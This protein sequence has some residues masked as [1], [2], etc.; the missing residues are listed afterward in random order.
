MTSAA[1]VV[2]ATATSSSHP[3]STRYETS[4]SR[5]PAR[6]PALAAGS[7]RVARRRAS[8]PPFSRLGGPAVSVGPVRF[9]RPIRANWS[10][11]RPEGLQD[12]DQ[13][14]GCCGPVR[15]TSGRGRPGRNSEPALRPTTRV[16]GDRTLQRRRRCGYPSPAGSRQPPS[17]WHSE[18]K[19]LGSIFAVH[20]E[21]KLFGCFVRST[22][23]RG[24]RVAPCPCLLPKMRGRGVSF[25]MVGLMSSRPLARFLVGAGSRAPG[26]VGRS[27]C[28]FV[29]NA[30]TGQ[31]GSPTRDAH[32]ERTGANTQWLRTSTE[33]RSPAT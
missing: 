11:F 6:C 3:G 27:H 20:S 22:A 12:A 8:A 10:A 24:Q 14:A 19:P 5:P 29:R 21:A 18:A 17:K 25:P 15:R 7:R 13:F 31:T 4:H 2:D 32:K 23:R 30:F 28:R 33:S 9:H 1:D 16:A 26:F